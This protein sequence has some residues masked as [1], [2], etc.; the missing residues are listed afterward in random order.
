MNSWPMA[1]RASATH[2]DQ[3]GCAMVDESLVVVESKDDEEV[4]VEAWGHIVKVRSMTMDGT[5]S[6][7]ICE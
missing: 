3:M 2:L 6:H 4:E 7:P 1:C 5:E